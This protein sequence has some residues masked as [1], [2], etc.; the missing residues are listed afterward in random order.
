MSARMLRKPICCLL[1]QHGAG[2]AVRPTCG[3]SPALRPGQGSGTPQ[4]RLHRGQAQ[5]GGHCPHSQAPGEE[6]RG[7]A[8]AT[9]SPH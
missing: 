5:R 9:A 8:T 3:V 2:H 1:K 7:T 4:D 6:G